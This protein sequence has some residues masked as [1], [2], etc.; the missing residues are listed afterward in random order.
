ML[1]H[2]KLSSATTGC[3]GLQALQTLAPFLPAEHTHEYTHTTTATTTTA[4]AFA[5]SMCYFANCN[6]GQDNKMASR[7]FV[8][9]SVLA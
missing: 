8:N 9:I 7:H 3:L 2:S 5:S 1:R 4:A 6:P